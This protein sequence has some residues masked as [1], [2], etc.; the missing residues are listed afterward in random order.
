MANEEARFSIPIDSDYSEPEQAARALEDLRRKIQGGTDRLKE[1]QAAQKRL[2]GTTVEVAKAQA[3]LQKKIDAE[4]SSIGSAQLKL[5]SMG[6]SFEQL[7]AKTRKA[8]AEQA[9]LADKLKAAGIE[10]AAAKTRALGNAVSSAGGPVAALKNKF[11]SLKDLAGNG[12]ALGLVTL[13]V[14]GLI[15]AVVALSVAA[16]KLGTDLARFIVQGANAARSAN[17]LREAVTGS[18]ADAGRLGDQVDELARRVPTGKD[19]LNELAVSLRKGGLSGQTLVDTLN[20]V[21][22]ASAA[23]GDDT[24]NKL[25]ELADRGKLTGRFQVNPQELMG[26]G[27]EFD[28]IAKALASSMKIGVSDARKALFEGRVKLAD[29]AAAMRKAVEDKFGGLNLRKML[30]LN[31]AAKKFGETVDMLTKGVDLEPFLRG[32]QLIGSAFDT[33]TVT[34]TA[35]KEIVTLVGR[36]LATTFEKGAPLV[37]K[38]IQGMVISLLTLTIVALKLRKQFRETFGDKEFLKGVNLTTVALETGRF[39]VTSFALGIASLIALVALAGVVLYQLV[40]PFIDI[41]LAIYG[42]LYAVQKFQEKLFGDIDWKATGLA[43]VDGIVGGIREGFSR[44]VNVVR[45]LG[46]RIKG[47]FTGKMEIKSPS[48]VMHRYGG[49]TVDGYVGGIDDG[50]PDAAKAMDGLGSQV[51]SAAGAG[52]AARSSSAAAA[53]PINVTI[54]APGATEATV[55]AMADE[56]FLR[57]ITGAVRDASQAMGALAPA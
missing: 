14:V 10:A 16:V 27:V 52:A 35:M 7:S 38:F 5:T 54:N 55:D 37:K 56:S 20:A 11:E 49:D 51:P 36:A 53:A 31:V 30:D 6:S 39:V 22:Q 2:T 29:G 45:E 28:N 9:K 15:A 13:G 18:A 24:G 21:A 1:M 32:F 48:K 50:I 23:V 19:A 43:I 33:S 26:S 8:T 12:G 3:E 57:K 47:A 34:G 40:K 4:R 46:D 17:L 25:R 41:G 44:A 42:A